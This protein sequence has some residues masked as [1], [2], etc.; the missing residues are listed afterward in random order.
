MKTSLRNTSMSNLSAIRS[1]NHLNDSMVFGID[2]IIY[3]LVKMKGG[4]LRIVGLLIVI[5]QATSWW[6]VGHM[7]TA[8]I[9]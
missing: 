9:A 8:A 1:K 3:L 5:Q 6:D 2:W 4:I 7:L